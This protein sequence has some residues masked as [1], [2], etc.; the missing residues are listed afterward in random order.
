MIYS[1]HLTVLR[2]LQLHQ[3]IKATIATQSV[4]IED[5][6]EEHIPF[7]K[8]RYTTF[9]AL[10]SQSPTKEHAVVTFMALLELAKQHILRIKQ[11]NLFDEIYIHYL[12]GED[13]H[14]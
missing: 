11:D 8:H 13:S 10:Y 3:P 4:T 1:A 2:R 7:Q 5:R 6:I 9:N 12:K 14:E